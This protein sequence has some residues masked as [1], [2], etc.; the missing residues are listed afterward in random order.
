MKAKNLAIKLLISLITLCIL[1]FILE[2][3]FRLPIIKEKTGGHWPVTYN[4]MIQAKDYELNSLGFR[5]YEHQQKK[6]DNTYRI[7]ILGDSY[8]YG[9]MVSPEKIFTR[10]LENL[11][12]QRLDRNIEII[13]MGLMGWNT[14]E[15]FEA[16]KTYGI[17]FEPDLVIIAFTF[18]DLQIKNNPTSIESQDPEKAII[19]IKKLDNFLDKKSYFYSFTKYKYN[20][21]LEKLNLKVSYGI[22]QRQLYQNQRAINQFTQA[23]INIDSLN[24]ANGAQ[25]LF[26]N[27]NFMPSG[28]SWGQERDFILNLVSSLGIKTFNLGAFL[29]DYPYQEVRISKSD[30][31]PNEF[32]HQIYAKVLTDY[33][34]KN[35][36]SF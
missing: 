28:S 31:H 16:L 8:V 25:T 23:M 30:G 12:N 3:F 18:N 17:S 24:Q 15:E 19:P 9:Q 14:V 5:D 26:T 34:I 27:L 13:S 10:Q 33:L 21:A 11:L 7:L 32:G 22:W 36:L 20:R 29:S 35:Y 2:I 6:P 4:W 1:F